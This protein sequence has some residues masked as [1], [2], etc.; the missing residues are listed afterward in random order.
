MPY[1]AERKQI[2]NVLRGIRKQFTPGTPDLEILSAVL[3]DTECN[4]ENVAAFVRGRRRFTTADVMTHFQVGKYKVAGS[5]AAL[6]RA[7]QIERI[8]KTDDSG[9]SA[10]RWVA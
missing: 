4:P 8:E 9:Y 1:A 10:Y 6:S 5:L 7:G 2:Q 3:S